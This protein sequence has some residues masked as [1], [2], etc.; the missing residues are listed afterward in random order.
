MHASWLCWNTN[1]RS[2]KAAERADDP[3][4]AKADYQ[5]LGALGSNADTNRPEL[6]EAKRYLQK[7]TERNHAS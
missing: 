2:A 5:Q 1:A 6:I 7:L 3:T 4:K